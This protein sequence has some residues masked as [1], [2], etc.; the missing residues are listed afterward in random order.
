MSESSET[1]VGYCPVQY[2]KAVKYL[3]GLLVQLHPQTCVGAGVQHA[4]HTRGLQRTHG[5]CTTKR[6]GVKKCQ[7]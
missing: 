3:C 2:G 1:F 6:S 7:K 5:G 4:M